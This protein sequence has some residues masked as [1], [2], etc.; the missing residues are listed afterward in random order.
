MLCHLVIQG[1]KIATSSIMFKS[2]V[3]RCPIPGL[4]GKQMMTSVMVSGASY[5]EVGFGAT[6]AGIEIPKNG[7]VIGMKIK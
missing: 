2:C 7:T 4:L 1:F 3:C 6:G 5:L